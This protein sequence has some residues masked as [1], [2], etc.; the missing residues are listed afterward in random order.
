M[1]TPQLEEVLAELSQLRAE[2]AALK[3]PP[4]PRK[5]RWV[6]AMTVAAVSTAA[7]AS[8]LTDGLYVFGAN[9]PAVASEVNANFSQ[10]RTWLRNKVGA[11]LN[12]TSIATPGGISAGANISA[13]GNI[14]AT[15]T[16]TGSS[17]SGAFTA[18]NNVTLGNGA[19]TLN[20]FGT[21]AAFG[22]AVAVTL[23]TT[24]TA[25]SD[26]FVVATIT[27]NSNCDPGPA[28]IIGSAGPGLA[29]R[30]QD[31]VHGGCL[32]VDYPTARGGFTM[33]VR[34]GEQY[35]VALAGNGGSYSTTASFIPIGR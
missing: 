12:S 11:D 26:G 32:N 30:A 2:V 3:A 22:T 8:T 29:V 9:E 7:F 23:G 33:P 4:T 34:K 20:L 10:L 14:T 5:T 28:S 13:T 15:G 17:W 27:S 1:A 21:T 31:S 35:S 25:T 19:S 16:V 24:N 18:A 6:V